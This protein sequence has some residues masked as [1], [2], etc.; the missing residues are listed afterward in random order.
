VFEL[1][2]E[3]EELGRGEKERRQRFV[4]VCGRVGGCERREVTRWLEDGSV[5]EGVSWLVV[6]RR[7]LSSRRKSKV[8]RHLGPGQIE[9]D[10]KAEEAEEGT[11]DE[12]K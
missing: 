8:L 3:M 12:F 1:A 4:A 7:A 11:D 6:A 5:E 10:E 2:A 9:E